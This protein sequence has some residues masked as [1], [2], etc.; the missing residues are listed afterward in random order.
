MSHKAYPE[1]GREGGWPTP[2]DHL[3]RFKESICQG[4]NSQGQDTLDSTV[5]DTP[6]EPVKLNR[7]QKK[8]QKQKGESQVIA[9]PPLASKGL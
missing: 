3:M 5:L 2:I 8:Q 6:Q 4:E 7:T 9:P 1:G